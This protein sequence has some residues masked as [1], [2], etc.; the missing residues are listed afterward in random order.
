MYVLAVNSP[1]FT[2]VFYLLSNQTI[3]SKPKE[4]QFNVK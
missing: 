1:E 4:S 3:L 2:A